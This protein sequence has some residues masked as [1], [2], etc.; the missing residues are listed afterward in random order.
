MI[1]LENQISV[2]DHLPIRYEDYQRHFAGCLVITQSGQL[3][4]QKRDSHCERFPGMLATFGGQVDRGETAE[5]GLIRE[6]HEELGAKVNR[7][8]LLALGAITKRG[9][10]N[11]LIHAYCWR[12]DKGS[13]T[14]CYE[15][16]PAFF[17]SVIE[18][19]DQPNIT[20][21]AHWIVTECVK[22]RLIF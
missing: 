14:G 2:I 10:D 18:I 11:A 8:G 9:L 12:D 20:A 6:L 15:G 21:D 17:K 13:I 22:R 7:N 1:R 5:Q 4:L 19:L 3:L 16:S